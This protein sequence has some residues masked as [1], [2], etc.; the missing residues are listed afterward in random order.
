ML[1]LIV[2]AGRVGSAVA[3]Q[4][5]EAGHDVSVLD[6]DPLSHEQLDKDLVDTWEDAGGRFTVGTALE[7]DALVEAGIEGADVFIASTRGD[8]TNLVVAQIAQK[9]FN[10]PRVVV[11]VADPARAAWYAE[12]GL[13]TICPTQHAIDLVAQ[14]AMSPA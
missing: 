13:H 2:G 14:A 3:K 10:V 5:L 6:Q 4:A 1:I 11:R 8:N 12:Q 7:V 9:R